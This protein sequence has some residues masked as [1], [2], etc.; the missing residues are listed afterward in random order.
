MNFIMA[1]I[2]VAAFIYLVFITV[3]RIIE[4]GVERLSDKKTYLDPFDSIMTLEMKMI[5]AKFNEIQ[6]RVFEEKK[7]SIEKIEWIRT[8]NKRLRD[9]SKY[10]G[11][12]DGERGY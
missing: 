5:D 8:I 2:Q 4:S 3:N 6:S 11:W 12:H 10:D 1:S 9:D 7:D